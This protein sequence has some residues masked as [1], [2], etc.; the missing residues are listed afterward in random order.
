MIDQVPPPS[1]EQLSPDRVRE[2]VDSVDVTSILEQVGDRDPTQAEA[3]AV[4]RIGRAAANLVKSFGVPWP[5][6]IAIGEFAA[7][8]AS[9]VGEPIRDVK[10]AVDEGGI[11]RVGFNDI[12]RYVPT[13]QEGAPGPEDETEAVESWSDE[14]RPSAR[15][16]AAE[17]YVRRWVDRLADLT[18]EGFPVGKPR[19]WTSDN[20]WT[21][22]RIAKAL[23][24]SSSTVGSAVTRLCKTGWLRQSFSPNISR[25][26]VYY[27]ATGT[28]SE[29][30]RNLF[31]DVSDDQIIQVLPVGEPDVSAGVEFGAPGT[32]R[33]VAESFDI[34][35]SMAA[36]RLKALFEA[37]KIGRVWGDMSIGATTAKA[38]VY[39][40]SSPVADNTT[41]AIPVEKGA[42]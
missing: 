39:Y 19:R 37:G 34:R 3:E 12:P 17:P 29:P 8:V 38:V 40:S 7:A 9:L 42:I 11:V 10:F 32:V 36:A 28:G 21:A 22:T 26:S 24:M 4:L 27:F 5:G 14:D 35:R 25:K 1:G 31:S 2:L 41:T 13:R 18:S 15:Y 23:G 6:V 20:E 30:E 33:A 16:R